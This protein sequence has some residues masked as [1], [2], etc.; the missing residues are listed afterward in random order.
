MPRG[1]LV[2]QNCSAASVHLEVG[3]GLGYSQSVLLCVCVWPAQYGECH[4]PG[5]AIPQC[6]DRS[7][8]SGTLKQLR[9]GQSRLRR[10]IKMYHLAFMR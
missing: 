1:R 9:D 6:R 3:L 2:E 10:K 7:E 8:L 4:F 5:K